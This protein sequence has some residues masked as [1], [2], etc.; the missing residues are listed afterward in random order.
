MIIDIIVFLMLEALTLLVPM[1]IAY[2][3]EK[4]SGRQITLFLI[5]GCIALWGV[6]FFSHSI[7]QDFLKYFEY[8]FIWVALFVIAMIV[9]GKSVV[10]KIIFSALFVLADLSAYLIVEKLIA[11]NDTMDNS[12]VRLYFSM[13]NLGTILL[14]RSI[15]LVLAV[16][17]CFLI[18]RAANT[19][20]G[21]E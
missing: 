5:C 1:Y 9:C 7:E 19:K 15:H 3:S 12:V 16:L 21:N 13:E 11:K 2:P 4:R 6:L 18:K 20:Q 8:V 10:R 14:E 17:I